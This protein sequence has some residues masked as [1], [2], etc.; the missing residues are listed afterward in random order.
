MREELDG[1]AT[2]DYLREI[3]PKKNLD[4]P[5]NGGGMGNEE[6]YWGKFIP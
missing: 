6:C 1:H 4:F 5:V 3:K 2:V